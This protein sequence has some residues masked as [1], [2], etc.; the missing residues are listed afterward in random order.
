MATGRATG[1]WS[2]T[3]CSTPGAAPSPAPPARRRNGRSRFM[4][5]TPTSILPRRSARMARFI[6]V[7]RIITCMPLTRTARSNG[8]ITPAARFTRPRRSGRTGRFIS[9]RTMGNSMPSIRMAPRNGRNLWPLTSSS[10]PRPSERT[11]RS[12]S[13]RTMATSMP[14]T[15]T[16]R[17]NGPMPSAVRPPLPRRSART[18]RLYLS[19]QS[20]T[21]YMP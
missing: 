11:G 18:G 12:M 20:I 8:R 15:R 5:S 1:T 21:R 19:A 7:R 14:S 16:A 3:T 6:S 17:G 2:T 9:V 10:L 4:P 13:A